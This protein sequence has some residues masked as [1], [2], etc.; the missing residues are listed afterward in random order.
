MVS[1]LMS[2]ENPLFNTNKAILLIS[3]AIGKIL[4]NEGGVAILMVGSFINVV[5]RQP[6]VPLSNGRGP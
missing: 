6:K 5:P 3:R 4:E 1:E 2:Q